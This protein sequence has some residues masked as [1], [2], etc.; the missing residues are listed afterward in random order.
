MRRSYH[1][2]I[3]PAYYIEDYRILDRGAVVEEKNELHAH[4]PFLSVFFLNFAKFCD[5]ELVFFLP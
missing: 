2:P 5:H 3:D 1:H 4:P